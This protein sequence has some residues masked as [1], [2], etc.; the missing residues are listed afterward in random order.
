MAIPPDAAVDVAHHH[1]IH[2]P[3]ASVIQDAGRRTSMPTK[4][5]ISP[6][7]TRQ[8]VHEDGGINDRTK[9]REA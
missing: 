9:W 8:D 7:T 2:A 3:T 4:S 6:D 1:P 5:Q